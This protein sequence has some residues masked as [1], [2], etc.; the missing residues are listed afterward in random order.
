MRRRHLFTSGAG[1]RHDWEDVG[2]GEYL[3]HSV[4]DTTP[5]LERNKALANHNDGYTPT[6][7]MRRVATI[8]TILRN[9]WLAEEG[10]D[11]F[12]PDLYAE[13]LMRKLNDPDYA[14]LRTAEGALGVSN[15]VLR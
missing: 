2:D 11:A 14:H 12:R 4:Q 1:V 3:I 8:P 15:G 6:R 5:V 7:E 13:K 10:W 9:K